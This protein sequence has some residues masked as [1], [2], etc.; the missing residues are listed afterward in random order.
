MGLL[1]EGEELK[2]VGTT[3]G[4]DNDGMDT[5]IRYYVWVGRT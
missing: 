2:C 5:D 4:M 1:L 3:F